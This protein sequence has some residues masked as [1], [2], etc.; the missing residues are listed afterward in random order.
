MCDEDWIVRVSDEGRGRWSSE[1][2]REEMLEGI[3]VYIVYATAL[4]PV[5]LPS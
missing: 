1:I 4:Y 5:F 2:K 3:Y